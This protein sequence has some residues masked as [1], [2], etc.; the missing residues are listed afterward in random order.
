MTKI[1][2]YKNLESSCIY[3]FFIQIV[4]RSQDDRLFSDTIDRLYIVN[5]TFDLRYIFSNEAVSTVRGVIALYDKDIERQ[6]S[7][8]QRNSRIIRIIWRTVFQEVAMDSSA[9]GFRIFVYP[10][11]EIIMMKVGKDKAGVFPI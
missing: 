5:D 2:I 6:V 4:K 7:H 1:A 9:N 8:F 3:S 11:G 10:S